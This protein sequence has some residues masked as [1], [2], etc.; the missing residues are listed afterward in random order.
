MRSEGFNK[1][2]D[3]LVTQVLEVS[4]KLF[5]Y[6]QELNLTDKEMNIGISILKNLQQNIK[7]LEE[8]VK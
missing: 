4:V 5:D 6:R 1:E 2:I 7:T 3:I 8:L